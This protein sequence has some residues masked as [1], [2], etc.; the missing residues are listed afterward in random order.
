MKAVILA[1]GEGRRLLPYTTVLPKPLMPIGNMPILEI[2]VRQLREY[3]FSEII[4]SVGHLA[5]LIQAFFGDGDNWG[6]KI[7]YSIENFPLGTAGPL[8]L[9]KDLEGTFLLMNGDILTTL[10]YT[11]FVDFHKKHDALLTVAAFERDSQINFGVIESKEAKIVNYV[12][13]PVYHFDVS[14]GVYCM[15]SKVLNY[16]DE[17]VRLDIPDLVLRLIKD[18]EPVK[19]YK[20]DCT[21]LD[22]G[23]VDDYEMA[24]TTFEKKRGL[25]LREFN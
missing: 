2:I 10:N 17:N 13:K 5:N 9:I 20:E 8:K 24:I 1:G 23:R 6:I 7:T 11:N 15:N 21:W 22:I 12:E 18:N 3:G 16:I 25:F 19:S 4:I 14:M